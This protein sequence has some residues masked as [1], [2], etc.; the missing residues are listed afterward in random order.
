MG[1][2]FT[3]LILLRGFTFTHF[4]LKNTLDTNN[5]RQGRETSIEKM[6]HSYVQFLNK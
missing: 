5:M 4:T 6:D 2:M 1:T 3:F